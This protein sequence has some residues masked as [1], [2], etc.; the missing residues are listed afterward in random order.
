M[1]EVLD[2]EAYISRMKH[3]KINY[4]R[5]LRKMAADWKAQN[6]RPN[7]LLHSCCAPCSTSSLEFL[8]EHADVTIFFSN[9]NIHPKSEYMRRANEQKLF[10]EKFNARTGHTVGF[11]DD[12]YRSNVFFKMVKEA[13][14]EEEPEGVLRCSACFDMRLDRAAEVAQERGFDYFGSAITLS[15]NKNSQLINEL[16]IGVQQNYDP[17]YLPSDFKKNNGYQRSIEM[18]HEY[19]VFRQC[20]CGCSFAAE[21]QGIDLRAVNK[22]AINYLKLKSVEIKQRG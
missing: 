3:Q 21:K 17:R 20:Y 2:V 4:D 18:C 13:G 14:L 15:K 5:V 11:I 16:G 7:V 8:A 6:Q 12:E 22:E 1:K 10:V 19:D 9:S